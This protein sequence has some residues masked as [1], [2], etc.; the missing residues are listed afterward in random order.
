MRREAESL[1]KPPIKWRPLGP[2]L[3]AGGLVLAASGFLLAGLQVTSDQTTSTEIAS[4]K[5][6]TGPPVP[7]PARVTYSDALEVKPGSLVQWGLLFILAGGTWTLFYY[8]EWLRECVSSRG[9]V[10]RP[11]PRVT[12]KRHRKPP[13]VADPAEP[14]KEQARREALEENQISAEL[15]FGLKIGAHSTLPVGAGNGYHYRSYVTESAQPSRT[16]G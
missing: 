10:L 6:N 14:L 9:V 16:G 4:T 1:S 13:V 7:K 2:M 8:W 12:W 3:L 15:F 5:G 11:F